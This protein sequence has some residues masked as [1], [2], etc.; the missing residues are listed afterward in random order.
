MGIVDKDRNDRVR[1]LRQRERQ[2]RRVLNALPYAVLLDVEGR[3]RYANDAALRL[4]GVAE[5][6]Q[7][8]QRPYADLI[9]TAMALGSERSEQQAVRRADGQLIEVEAFT[10]IMGS[11]R[12]RFR[13]TVL[14]PLSPA[15]TPGAEPLRTSGMPGTASVMLDVIGQVVQWSQTAEELLGYTAGDMIGKQFS[16][17][18]PEEES[19]H[20]HF[21]EVLR[22]AM[23]RGVCQIE[24]WKRR[25]DGT[26]FYAIQQVATLVDRGG[27]LSGFS[28]F[29]RSSES[30]QARAYAARFTEEQMRQAQRM[31]AV[32]RLA[33]GIAHDFNNLLTA[34]QG[35]AQFLTED[36][37]PDHPSR[38]DV[39]EILHSSERAAALTRQLLTFSRGQ[40][41]PPETIEINTVVTAMERLL[42]RVISEDISV[43]SILDPQLWS[44]RA[45]PTQIEQI[46]VNLIVNARDAMPRGGRITIRTTNAELSEA[47]AQ[48]H[49]E[50][51]PGEYVMLAV[52][53]TGIGMDKD[54]QAH[55]FEPFFTTKGPEQGTG[56][57]LSTVFGIVKQMGGH[58]YVY[59]EVGQG[60]TFK[61]YIP[62]AGA[63]PRLVAADEIGN[64]SRD[65]EV[66]LI[67]EDDDSVRALARRVLEA[68]GYRVRI[69]AAP[70]EALRIMGEYGADLSLL[71]TDVVL[72]G[73]SGQMLARRARELCP[74]L[75]VIYM[76]GYTTEEVQRNTDLSDNDRFLE[77]PFTPEALAKSVRTALDDAR[78]SLQ[79]SRP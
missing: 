77:K 7:L 13:Q 76:S 25:K 48:R 63:S 53:D 56:L 35:H 30:P 79:Q 70:D 67:V 28:L 44:V 31:E 2:Y 27:E 62:R 66:V 59:S 72:P 5:P 21:D 65:G 50:V 16:L 73:M 75:P 29:I 24:G 32:G 45:D 58:I 39:E 51:Q 18:I 33:S 8:Q 12:R 19:E 10:R 52:S 43:E 69:S 68:R 74:H 71:L 78:L 47:Y 9:I 60:T 34:I 55:I 11:G 40:S 37:E 36:L 46:L 15:A 61:V 1:R 4:F 38:A 64:H 42:R 23:A 6:R 26:R 49:E 22:A 54:T 14:R 20:Y 3:I 41:L 17:L 57:G